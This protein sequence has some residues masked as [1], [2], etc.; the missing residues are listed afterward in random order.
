MIEKRFLADGTLF[1]LFSHL[2]PWQE[3]FDCL[4]PLQIFKAQQRCHCLFSQPTSNTRTHEHTSKRAS[5]QS[6]DCKHTERGGKK[7]PRSFSAFS[8][9]SRRLARTLRDADVD[10]GGFLNT[11]GRPHIRGSQHGEVCKATA[12]R[13]FYVWYFLF[14][15][16]D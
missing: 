11:Q 5:C 12:M 14:F 2:L 13:D 3:M 7:K 9:V 4:K 6:P 15:S 16:L 8:V 10:V 1:G